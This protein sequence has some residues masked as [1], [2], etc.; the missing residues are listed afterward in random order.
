MRMVV[1]A[2][3]SVSI[4]RIG[5]TTAYKRVSAAPAWEAKLMVLC[6]RY[7]TKLVVPT[8]SQNVGCRA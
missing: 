5:G 3:R 8:V 1:A 4:H 2:A 7:T 6:S